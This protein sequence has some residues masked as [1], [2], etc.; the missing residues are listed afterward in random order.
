M[1]VV[2]GIDP[3][4]SCGWCVAHVDTETN[5]V[6]ILDCGHVEIPKSEFTGDMCLNI[7]EQIKQLFEEYQVDEMV[8]EDYIFS[9][10]K[11]QGAHL[12]LYIRGA[13]HMLCRSMGKKY[14]ISSVSSWKSIIAGRSMP[15][16]EMKK[17]YGK[18]LAN[19]IFIQEALWVRYNIRF[20]NH[21][22]SQ[23]TKKPVALKYDMV[24][25]VAITIAY[26]YSQYNIKD[27]VFEKEFPVD[28]GKMKKP[29]QYVYAL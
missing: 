12:N 4:I 19:K 11:C 21:S 1:T 22:I 13:L 8:I 28:L 25:A 23:K 7:Q 26:V 10:R 6:R 29:K 27:V 15:T 3:A 18:E 9:G 17:F 14:T 5:S 2:L 20:P 16:G 24:D